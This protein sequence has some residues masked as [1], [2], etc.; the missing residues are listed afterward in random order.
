MRQREPIAPRQVAARL[1]I[2]TVVVEQAIEL[3]EHRVGLAGEF[4]HT[5]KDILGL[6][7]VE[8]HSSASWPLTDGASFY[9]RRRA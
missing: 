3:D 9:R 8:E 6:L 1:L 2:Q 5:G 4:R 7:A